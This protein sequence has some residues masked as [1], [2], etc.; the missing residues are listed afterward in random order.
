MG[1]ASVKITAE[2]YSHLLHKQLKLGF[3]DKMEGLYL[4]QPDATP[5]QPE[6]Q[7]EAPEIVIDCG[8]RGDSNPHEFRR[9][10]LSS[11]RTK[12]Q[13]VTSSDTNCD[14]LLRKPCQ[15]RLS[16]GASPLRNAQ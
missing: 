11:R 1:H 7:M 12:T 3:T 15:A 8:E 2:V 13:R 9:Q 6:P 14:E 16:S 10:I 4:P 5:A